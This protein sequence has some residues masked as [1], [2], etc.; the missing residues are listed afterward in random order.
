MADMEYGRAAARRL[1]SSQFRERPVPDSDKKNLPKILAGVGL[2][3]GLIIAGGARSSAPVGLVI[4]CTV[5]GYFVGQYLSKGESKA[6][7][8]VKK[9]NEEMREHVAHLIRETRKLQSEDIV[10]AFLRV[11][12]RTQLEPSQLR[13]FGAEYRLDEERGLLDTET[14]EERLGAL[15]DRSVRLVS[16][17]QFSNKALRRVRFLDDEGALT[18]RETLYNPT[19]LVALLISR[20]ELIILD[21]E[22]DCMDGDLKETI[23]RMML[24][25][26]V[27]ISMSAERRR[28]RIGKV[29]SGG[30]DDQDADSLA[31]VD[32][33]AIGDEKSEE[34]EKTSGDESTEAD[35]VIEQL[36]STMEISRT[37]GSK[38]AFPIKRRLLFGA[39][40]G[41]LD[42]E[43]TLT[44]DEVATDKIVNELNRVVRESRNRALA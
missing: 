18:R 40:A 33:V 10:K 27:S 20:E 4:V 32:E 39:H 19:R 26:I 22:T 7:K 23:L 5:I 29:K 43:L 2:V 31:Q 25:D 12:E 34:D 14:A 28:L 9:A 37:D 13:A 3:V 11:F 21:V 6:Q 16:Q 44:E 17:G 35:L 36:S 42:Q 24:T 41:A 30:R 38:V 1:F 15:L 8:E